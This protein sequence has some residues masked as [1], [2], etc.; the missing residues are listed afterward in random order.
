MKSPVL[1]LIPG[2][3]GEL[4]EIFFLKFGNTVL[5]VRLWIAT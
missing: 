1:K 4:A 5:L 2:L 3:E